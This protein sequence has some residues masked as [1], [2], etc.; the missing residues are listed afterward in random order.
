MW[1]PTNSSCSAMFYIPLLQITSASR[2][3][4]RSC[5]SADVLKN[6]GQSMNYK[7][8]DPEHSPS[9][10]HCMVI[11][12]G[13]SSMFLLRTNDVINDN[14]FFYFCWQENV[15]WMP[16]ISIACVIIYVIGHAI[17]PS[18]PDPPVVIYSDA[19][20]SSCSISWSAAW[21]RHVITD[22]VNSAL[23]RAWCQPPLCG[24]RRRIVCCSV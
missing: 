14:V 8:T 19:G 4:K 24:S 12:A 6:P 3:K 1:G 5:I 7:Q 21:T 22:L 2:K 15:S 11:M 17:G 13:H 20:Y 16:Y 18:K 10:N 9:W 23:W